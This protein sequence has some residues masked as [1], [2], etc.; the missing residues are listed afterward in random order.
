MKF[1]RSYDWDFKN[2]Y[3]LFKYSLNRKGSWCMSNTQYCYF[4]ISRRRLN[5]K[6]HM[7]LPQTCGVIAGWSEQLVQMVA[8]VNM[9]WQH[10]QVVHW[11]QVFVH[12]TFIIKKLWH[13]ILNQMPSLQLPVPSLQFW[14]RGMSRGEILA[15]QMLCQ[16]INISGTGHVGLLWYLLPVPKRQLIFMIF[17]MEIL[18]FQC[19]CFES[20]GFIVNHQW[21]L[22]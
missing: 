4:P 14:Q 7:G 18:W 16:R 17:V 10:L 5:I 8:L 21:A 22:K 1:S 15:L 2:I 12:G 13:S 3:A 19:V 9:L 6:L 20:L 11:T